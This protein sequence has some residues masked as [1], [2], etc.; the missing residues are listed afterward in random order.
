MEDHVSSGNVTITTHNDMH[1]TGDNVT[2]NSNR[3]HVSHI[4]TCD[5]EGVHYGGGS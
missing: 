1:T 3:D 5:S 2:I 4:S